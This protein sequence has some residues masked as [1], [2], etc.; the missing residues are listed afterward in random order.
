LAFAKGTSGAQQASAK[1]AAKK[2]SRVASRVAGV[3]AEVPCSV[4]AAP[5]PHAPPRPA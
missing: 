2:A 1:P 4:M 3:S 5:D